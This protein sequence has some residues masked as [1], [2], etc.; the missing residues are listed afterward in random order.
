MSV[1]MEIAECLRFIGWYATKKGRILGSLFDAGKGRLVAKLI[2]RRGAYQRPF[3]HLGMVSL[4]VLA[5]VLAPILYNRYPTKATGG[6]ETASPSEVLNTVTAATISTTTIESEKPRRDVE[7]Y[8]VRG[9][10]TLSA[11][12]KKFGVDVD[13]IKYLNSD[14]SIN[15]LHPGDKIKIPPVSG[16]ILKVKSGD[17]IYSLAKKYGLPSSQ[18][19]IDWPYNNFV[20]DEKFTLAAGQDLVIPG[21]VPPEVAAPPPVRSTPSVGLF[22]H[23]SGT[24]VWP[25]NGIITQYFSWYHNGTDIANGIGTPV[26]AADAGRVVTVLYDNHDYGY[27]V[28]ID[29]GN[30]LRTLYGHLSQIFVNIGDNLGR[31]EILGKMGSTGRS[32]GP[33]LHFTVY[34]GGS[35]VNPLLF[36]K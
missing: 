8:E 21:G 34:S 17:T 11:I 32:T 2:V 28:I 33:H 23:G 4:L 30:G 27:H 20:D 5:M 19:I 6:S 12:A 7:E 3:L 31:G 29:H 13:S 26:R 15:N 36:L 22:A 18:P 16:V 14:I 24:L 1:N 35:A 10:D 9:G 25:T